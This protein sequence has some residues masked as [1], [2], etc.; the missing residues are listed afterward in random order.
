MVVGDGLDL[1][2]GFEP[3]AYGAVGEE[4]GE[5]GADGQLGS[6]RMEWKGGCNG[7]ELTQNT[8]RGT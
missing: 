6:W 8:R 2:G 4:A 3:G 5:K 1:I 7:F